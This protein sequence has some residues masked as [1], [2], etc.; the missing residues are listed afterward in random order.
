MKPLNYS[1][2]PVIIFVEPQRDLEEIFMQ[3]NSKISKVFLPSKSMVTE[4][5]NN[6]QNSSFEFI[7]Y[8]TIDPIQDELIYKHSRRVAEI[9]VNLLASNLRQMIDNTEKYFSSC[10]FDASKVALTDRLASLIRPHLSFIQY[11]IEHSIE[12]ITYVPSAS[13]NIPVLERIYLANGIKIEW[14]TGHIQNLSK[15]YENWKPVQHVRVPYSYKSVSY[16]K[17]KGRRGV[18][19]GGLGSEQYCYT[20]IPVIRELTQSFSIDLCNVNASL[21]SR[22]KEVERE[23]TGDAL[24][25]GLNLWQRESKTYKVEVSKLHKKAIPAFVNLER[26]LGLIAIDC[27]DEIVSTLVEFSKLTFLRYVIPTI[28]LAK[29]I[30]RQFKDLIK[31]SDFLICAPSRSI[32]AQ[33]FISVARKIGVPSFEIQGGPISSSA[34]FIAPKTSKVLCYDPYSKNVYGDL[35][36]SHE[37]L[38]IIGSTRIDYKKESYF[39]GNVTSLAVADDCEADIVFLLATQPVGIYLSG[40]ILRICCEALS[41]VNN[42]K[43]LLKQHPNESEEYIHNYK[44]ILSE[45]N[46]KC[47][48]VESNVNIYDCINVSDFV[49]TYYSTVGIEAFCFGKNVLSIWPEMT[50]PP[51]DLAALGIAH[52]IVSSEELLML[53]K[54]KVRLDVESEVLKLR[55]GLA[56]FRVHESLEKILSEQ[57]RKVAKKLRYRY[58]LMRLPYKK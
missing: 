43:L 1:S 25:G 13:S 58:R 53:L 48:I 37:S 7:E 42:C 49:V 38:D 40:K 22:H 46:V 41:S 55:D 11:C 52:K 20:L 44:Q 16:R 51:F 8:K 15:C 6:F 33:V 21:G 34:R 30:F 17:R 18:V 29:E 3:F 28:V 27:D 24:L 45:Y 56:S 14:Y 4:I 54:G 10:I 39:K 19:V 32:E 2:E 5:K 12:Q 50:P 31:S 36:V 57:P 9:G 47:E 26:R 23:L 35:G